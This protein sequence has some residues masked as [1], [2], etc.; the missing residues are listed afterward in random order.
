ME[1]LPRSPALP[2]ARDHA[3]AP[4]RC[5]TLQDI[6]RHVGLSR[7]AVSMALRGDRTI[8]AATRERIEQA[9][10]HLGYRPNPLVASLMTLQRQRRS[11]AAVRTTLAYLS[12]HDWQSIPSYRAMFAGAQ[13]RAM[14]V[15]CTLEEFKLHAPGMTPSRMRTILKTRGIHAVVVA[16]LPYGE[17]S[18]D[19]DFSSLI[20]VGLGMSLNEPLLERVGNDHFQS[21]VLA[22]EKCL[23][24]GYRRIGLMVS[25]ACSRR[26]D[27]RWLGGYQFALQR[28]GV[29]ALPPLS[30]EDVGEIPAA[31][32]AWHARHR[33]DVVISGHEPV[34]RDIFE[35]LP[36]EMGVVVLG[37]ASIDSPWAGIYQNWHLIGRMAAER[38]ISRFYTNNF[39]P[40]QQA[41]LHLIAGRWTPGQSA[42]GPGRIRPPA[43]R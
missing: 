7:A 17:R 20:A 14:E 13:Q 6:A 35:R 29:A 36:P 3:A 15:H 41:Y 33:P 12:C 8:P 34:H 9:A 28:A 16:P 24:L 37:A 2:A 23:E 32:P 38:V 40:L 11:V 27:H 18:L 10:R 4:E 19:F 22:V 1:K 42:P 5:P 39:E 26:L 30:P 21:S 43:V 25:E 31:F